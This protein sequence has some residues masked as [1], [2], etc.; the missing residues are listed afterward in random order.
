MALWI[1][2]FFSFFNT[3]QIIDMKRKSNRSEM[4]SMRPDDM[5]FPLFPLQNSITKSIT[6]QGGTKKEGGSC[7]FVGELFAKHRPKDSELN[8]MSEMF[9]LNKRSSFL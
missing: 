7:D 5:S 6:L 9:V 3:N 8:Q 4:R 2:I 1:E